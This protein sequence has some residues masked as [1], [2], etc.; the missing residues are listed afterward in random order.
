LN[1]ANATVSPQLFAPA[2]GSGVDG[3]LPV[4]V[5]Q[6]RGVRASK[7]GMYAL[8]DVDL[9][10]I[11]SAPDA[12]AM[13]GI[14]MRAFYTEAE[15]YCEERRSMLL[16]DI[17]TNVVRLDQMQGWLNDNESLR[18]ANA[19]VYYPRARIPDPLNRGRLRSL[20]ASGTIAGLYARTDVQR[21]VWKAPA[22]TE[23]SL[24]NVQAL[25]YVLTD[26]ENG[27]LNP[28]GINCLRTFPIYSNICWG[29]RTGNMC[30]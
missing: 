19:A 22:G 17:P 23:A 13:S 5:A 29:A 27:A 10:N 16:I 24:I 4:A 3:T 30:R 12:A 6:Y 9:F 15:V 8:E 11:M 26:L 7:T 20:G 18:N 1:P 2:A 14:D 21:G 25:D 28:L